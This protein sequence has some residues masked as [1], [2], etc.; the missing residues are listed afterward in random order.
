MRSFRSKLGSDDIQKLLL[1]DAYVIDILNTVRDYGPPGAFVAAGFVRNRIWDA[2]YDQQGEYEDA[3]IDVVY[4]DRDKASKEYELKLKIRLEARWQ[5][6]NQARMHYFGGHKPFE[7]LRHALMH[8]A[9]TA[10]TVGVRFGST[11]KLEFV[12]P[13]GLTDLR[14]HILRI[15]PIMKASDPQ[16]FD[17]RLTDKGWLT[18]WPDLEVLR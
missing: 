12:A 11:D 7:D 18:R 14:A 17:K 15:S 4:F 10:T 8:W 16:G 1:K 2:L 5:V 3:D 6:R 13:F 9:E